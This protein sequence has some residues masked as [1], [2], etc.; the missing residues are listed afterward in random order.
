MILLF[1]IIFYEYLTTV[2]LIN[3]INNNIDRGTEINLSPA[4]PQKTRL[5][6]LVS[7]IVLYCTY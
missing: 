7:P 6:Y 2:V 4:K 1:S 3:L 5:V